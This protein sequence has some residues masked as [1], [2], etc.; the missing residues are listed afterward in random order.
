[1]NN[2]R[3]SPARLIICL[4]LTV[5][6][7][8]C[9]KT[10][11]NNGGGP[12]SGGG[13]DQVSV[14]AVTGYVYNENGL[15]IANA[16]VTI[17][18]T[19]VFSNSQGYFEAKNV[20]VNNSAAILSVEKAGYFKSV[21]TFIPAAGKPAYLEIRLLPKNTISTFSAATGATI[22]ASSGA[23]IS[24]PA[25][26]VV[27]ALTNAAYT[28]TVNLSAYIINADNPNLSALMP[29]DLRGIDSSNTVRLLSTYGMIAVELTGSGG[30]LLQIAPGKKA[31]LA[32]TIPVAMRTNAPAT[33]PLWYFDETKGMWKEEGSAVKSGTRYTGQVSHF[34]VWNWDIRT[35]FVRLTCSLKDNSGRP[36][37][38]ALVRVTDITNAAITAFGYAD[39]NGD[40][41]APV[42]ANA[43]L[44]LEVNSSYNQCTPGQYFQNFTTTNVNISLGTIQLPF[45]YDLA[46]ITG[47]VTNCNG[48]PM[49]EGHV[50]VNVNNQSWMIYPVTNGA[51]SFIE[52]PC[53]GPQNLSIYAEDFNTLQR[54]S[55][56]V[57]LTVNPGSNITVPNIAACG[58]TITDYIKYRVDG[59]PHLYSNLTSDLFFINP[60]NG[61]DLL[62]GIMFNNYRAINMYGINCIFNNNNIAPGSTQTITNMYIY[63][64]MAADSSNTPLQLHMTEYGGYGQY[65]S[66]NFTGSFTNINPPVRNHTIDCTFRWRR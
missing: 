60:M 3:K 17:G 42:P 37:P 25:N 43:Q 32:V 41:R 18:T 27:N 64:E 24:I 44:K 56:Q 13:A 36:V 49:Q 33:I 8:T 59:V 1:M 65:V 23:S 30:E 28:G 46:T 38:Y 54:S 15:A 10:D 48:T 66:G 47:T 4:I 63:P 55:A 45:S 14:S 40:V 61:N 50:V 12:G 20:F 39:A 62:R 22:S 53:S 7:V 35:N 31:T 58:T 5:F 9:K 19:T 29:G 34:S 57:T 16:P 6:I 52:L 2:F 26:G 11:T 21:K 51:Y